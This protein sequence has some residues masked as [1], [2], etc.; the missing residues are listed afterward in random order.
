MMAE[1]EICDATLEDIEYLA[2][3][4]RDIDKREIAAVSG[5]ST[6][7]VLMSG[8]TKSEYCKV[9]IVDGVPMCIYGVSRAGALSG[10]GYI[11][12]LG[13]DEIDKHAVKFIRGCAIQISEI[14]KDF[15]LVENWCHAENK[16]TIRWLKWLGFTFEDPK[17]YGRKKEMFHKFYMEVV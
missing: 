13:T 16:K 10:V 11:W 6:K 14:V 5:R 15:N 1:Y 17:P 9:A 12:L 4:L 8:A 2:S 7:A 3:N